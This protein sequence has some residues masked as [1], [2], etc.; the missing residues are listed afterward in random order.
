MPDINEW[1]R[2]SGYHYIDFDTVLRDVNGNV[3]SSLFLSDNIHPNEAGHQRL[4]NRILLDC[5]FLM[6]D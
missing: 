5:P 4:Y 1:I 2:N 3:D 6:K